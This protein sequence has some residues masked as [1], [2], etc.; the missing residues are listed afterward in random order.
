[1]REAAMELG[2]RCGPRRRKQSEDVPLALRQ[3]VVTQVGQVQPDP[4]RG[5]VNGWNQTQ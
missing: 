1:V 2:N 4:V 3:T 5:S